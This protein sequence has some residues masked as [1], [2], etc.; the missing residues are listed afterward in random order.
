ML[1]RQQR[2]QRRTM[3]WFVA[4]GEVQERRFI[5]TGFFSSVQIFLI[6]YTSEFIYFI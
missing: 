6:V 5:R 2:K 3:S 1:H 4:K